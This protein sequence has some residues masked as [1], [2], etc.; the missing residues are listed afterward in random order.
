MAIT[1]QDKIKSLPKERQEI[2]R[3]NTAKL[4]QQEYKLREAEKQEE[5]STKESSYAS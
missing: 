2:I 5:L 4:I 3:R 1:L